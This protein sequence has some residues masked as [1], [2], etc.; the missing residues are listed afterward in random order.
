MRPSYSKKL[1]SLAFVALLPLFSCADKKA[2]TDT[3]PTVA[4]SLLPQAWFV[5][6]IAGE[7]V[8]VLVVVG[9]GQSPHDYEP[10]PRQLEGLSKAAFWLLSGSDFEESL[11]PK[12]S[13]MYPGLKII[14]GTAGVALR[15]LQDFE[16]D[17]E[18]AGAEGINIDRHSWL[19][20]E[21]AKIMANHILSGLLNIEAL[22]GEGYQYKYESLIEEID[23]TFQAIAGRVAPLA[24]SQVLV[25]HPA[26]GYFLDEFGLKQVAVEVGGKEPTPKAL[27]ALVREARANN[28]RAIF[29]QTQFPKDSAKSLAK[30]LN[31]DVLPL[32]PL[33]EDWL[34]N[35]RVMGRAL[36]KALVE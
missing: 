7:D 2:K 25:F 20:R 12:I 30:S 17:H 4:V 21:P 32:D 26:F 27:A 14:D 8:R 10:S 34:E 29:V 33:A 31:I 36:E 15:R 18:H 3:R 28:A 11:V 16:I 5:R 9:E 22:A 6:Q 13:Q 24:G 35:I 23:A 1:M 19:G